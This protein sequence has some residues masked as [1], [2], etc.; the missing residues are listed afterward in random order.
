MNTEKNKLV[1]FI[2]EQS[3]GKMN[4]YSLLVQC[5][6]IS[7]MLTVRVHNLINYPKKVNLM[8]TSFSCIQTTCEMIFLEEKKTYT[9]T[10][11]HDYNI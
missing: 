10:S 2:Y 5:W 1:F 7:K 8:C 3:N 11:V 4:Y 9:N 6:A